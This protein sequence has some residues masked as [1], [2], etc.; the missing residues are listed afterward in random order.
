M[1]TS[2]RDVLKLAGL[3]LAGGSFPSIIVPSKSFGGVNSETLKVGLI[4]CGGRGSGAAKQAL[5]ADSNVVLHAMGD[6]FGDKLEA[7]LTGL[8]K[9]HGDKVKV[10]DGHKFLGFDA[11]QKVID[12]GVDVVLLA[13]PPHFRPQH[14][15]AAVKAGKHVFCEKP[16]AVDGPGV[17]KVLEVAKEAKKKNLSLVSGFCWRYDEP[18]RASFGKIL[19]GSIGDVHTVYNTYYTGLLWSHPRKEGWTDIEFQLRNWMYYTW[20]AGDH[21]VEQ[22]VHSIDMMSWAFGDKLP[23]SAIGT[24]GRQVRTDPLFGHIYDH[25]AITYEYPDGKKGFHFS[26]QQANTDTSY[27]VE[28]LGSKGRAMVDC[29]KRVHEITGAN[30]WKYSGPTSDMYQNEHNELFASIRNGKPM[31]D[32]EWMSNSTLLAI[33]GRM[34]AYTGKR[35]TWEQA[36]NS[37][38]RLGPDTYTWNTAVP[39]AEVA[40]PGFTAFS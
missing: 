35:I 29:S 37:Q 26:R 10:D 32:G 2:R 6:I 23:V 39:V 15:E 21:I 12:S 25:F 16:V 34:A 11:F 1:A 5:S 4:G 7:S 3:A 30:N 20:L 38:E 18:K 27:L 28:S 33:M 19:D 36:L 24:G 14:L 17:R 22:A 8:K 40:K 9:V 31:N 13:T